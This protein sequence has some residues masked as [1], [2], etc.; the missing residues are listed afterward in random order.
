MTSNAKLERDD[1]YQAARNRLRLIREGILTPSD[2]R[3][4]S[5]AR[6]VSVAME[7]HAQKG[8]RQN[9]TPLFSI[10][11]TRSYRFANAIGATSYHF[12]HSSVAKVTFETHR[13]GIRN[14]PG[15]AK[16][17]G[18]YIERSGATAKLKQESEQKQQAAAKGLASHP[19]DHSLLIDHELSGT[20]Q[21]HDAYLT[22]PSAIGEIDGGIRAILTNIDTDDQKRSEFWSL[23]EKHEADPS[24]DKMTINRELNPQF[25]QGVLED[26]K[27]PPA[28]RAALT[29]NAPDALNKFTISS[30]KKVRQYLRMQPGWGD[31]Q[32][33][34]NQQKPEAGTGTREAKKAPLTNFHDGRGGRTQYRIVGELPEELSPEQCFEIVAEFAEEFKKRGIPYVAV[35]HAPDHNN[36]DR[37]WHFHLDYYDRPCRRI[38]DDDITNLN[39]K[40]YKT[41]GLTAGQWDFSVV[42]PKRNRTNGRA[43]PLKQ[44]K[45]KEVGKRDWPERLRKRLADIKNKHMA[46]A[47]VSRRV[48]HRSYQQMGID[49]VPQIHLNSSKAAIESRGGVTKDASTNEER[50]WNAIIKHLENQYT[51]R[52]AENADRVR[53]F[54]L[55]FSAMRGFTAPEN[56][57]KKFSAFLDVGAGLQHRASILQQ[58]VDRGKSRAEML[59]RK[60]SPGGNELPQHATTRAQARSVDRDKLRDDS[61][62]YLRWFDNETANERALIGQLKRQAAAL[63]KAADVLEL[64]LKNWVAPSPT[65]IKAPKAE[66]VKPANPTPQSA[67]PAAN[68]KYIERPIERKPITPGSVRMPAPDESDSAPQ[69]LVNWQVAEATADS[70][71]HSGAEKIE[72]EK[73]ERERDRLAAVLLVYPRD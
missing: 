31:A 9:S 23:V 21:T 50:Q 73:A 41:D 24:P 72:Q 57:I 11:A 22:R 70:Q 18:R 43:T 47:G 6:R 67:E 59:I 28:I 29:S 63:S 3:L 71:R 15:A 60:N 65:Q 16:A 25:W 34:T 19:S 12:S 7:D 40:G 62:S 55:Y 17:H 10:P 44:N 56:T 14:S 39:D 42:T 64:N 38:T 53:Q 46:R 20:E 54:Q 68:K 61:A 27:C 2:N 48:D 49:A 58:E 8:S 36:D 26:D 5:G 35:M 33:T 69:E 37:N 1:E 32:N 4:F 66:T 51:R 30:G 13:D 52:V 45:V